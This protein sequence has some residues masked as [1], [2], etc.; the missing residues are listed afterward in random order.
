MIILNINTDLIISFFIKEKVS[1]IKGV[2]VILTFSFLVNILYESFVNQY[3]VI[4]NLF[5]QINKIKITILSSA[6]I[7]G[8]PFVYFKGIYGAAL[9]NLLYE[10]IGLAYAARIYLETK[11]KENYSIIDS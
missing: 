10:I 3:L 2:V 8:I 11:D 6:F 7:L 1:E 4:N 5:K 9:T